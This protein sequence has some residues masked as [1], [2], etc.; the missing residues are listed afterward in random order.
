[1]IGTVWTTDPERGLRIARQLRAG[2]YGVNSVYPGAAAFTRRDH[3]ADFGGR[4]TDPA[5]VGNRWARIGKAAA[6]SRRQAR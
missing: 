4:G 1:V 3:C 6:P 2:S 5:L